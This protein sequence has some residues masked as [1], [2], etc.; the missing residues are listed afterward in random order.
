[1]W[2]PSR[3]PQTG[4]TALVEM[5]RVLQVLD[6]DHA[7]ANLHPQPCLEQ[8]TQLLEEYRRVRL[9]VAADLDVHLS[10]DAACGLTVGR[11]FQESLIDVLR[12]GLPP[13][14]A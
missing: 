4:R 1:M 2:R 3:L 6:P 12:H 14:H 9:V 7:S 8:L 11:V 13:Q 10:A 5:R